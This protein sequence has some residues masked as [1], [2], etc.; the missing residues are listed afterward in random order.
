MEL[1]ALAYVMVPAD[2]ANMAAAFAKFWPGWNRPISRRWLGDHKTVVGLLLGIAAGLLASYLQSRISWSPRGLQPAHWVAL[3]LAQG[4]GAM[5]GDAVKSFFKRRIGIAPGHSWIPADELDFIVG[6]MVFGWPWLRL[7][8]IE[9][10]LILGF[11]FVGHIA[12]NHVAFRFGIRDA[13][14]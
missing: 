6:A 9:V 2:A 12:T 14:W 8:P 3:G 10:A 11:T 7:Q 1:V 13:Q 4:A 5:F